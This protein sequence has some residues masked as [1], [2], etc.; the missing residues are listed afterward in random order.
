[1]M[2]RYVLGGLVVGVMA[3]AVAGA[4]MRAA[5]S[6]PTFA[7]DVLPI[8]QKDCQGC[9]RPGQIAP[10]SL[11]TY[12]DAR[13]WAR[14]IKAKVESRQ[15]PPWFADPQYGHFM[16]DRS[17]KPSEVET[18]VKW[19]DGG[20]PQG[21]PKDAP[22]QRTW[23][24]NG[25]FI[26]PDV[27]VKGPEFQVPA[28][29]KNNV[30]EWTN[31]TVP[32]G[33]TKD[34]WITSLEIKPSDLSVTHHICISFVPHR[35][36]VHYYTPIWRDTPRD[37]E[38]VIVRPADGQPAANA[39]PPAQGAQPEALQGGQGGQGGVGVP[40]GTGTRTV[41]AGGFEGCYVPGTQFADYRPFHAGKL[42]PANTDIV[43][44]VH[45]TP[46]GKDVVDV[47][48]IGFTVSA[49]P[50][51]KRYISYNISGAG[52]MFAIPPND[53]NYS[54]P[55]AEATFGADAELVDM[56][57][58]MHL[59][60]K[61]MAYHLVY[62]DGRDEIVLSVPHYDFNWQVVYN[63]AEPVHIPKG[64]KLHVDA[65]YNNSASNK[66]NPNPNRTVYPGTMTW[67]EMMSPFFG[68]IVDRNIDPRTVLQRARG[69]VEG[70]GA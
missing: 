45:Y 47:P 56:M 49:T 12:E 21:N 20:A 25:W 13:P 48:M 39:R 65:H 32:S 44:Q 28:H 27:I 19:V 6:T 51:E 9:H 46:T 11:L 68:V 38:G 15:M 52:P 5:D 3:M 17:L 37:E 29:P 23:P 67:E 64:T 36:D 8:L 34:T 60:G 42:V 69:T 70:A 57:P 59:R 40:P 4:T 50:P 30:I 26:K 63:P 55:P 53:G 24:E 43:F 35:D 1:M 14:D 31:I 22:P 2:K 66:F 33:F 54:S 62:P 18:I 41:G 61:D 58:H 16:N 7:K 10:M